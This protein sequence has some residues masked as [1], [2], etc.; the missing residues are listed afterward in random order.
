CFLWGRKRRE[1][2]RVCFL[3]HVLKPTQPLPKA[4]R[5]C[6]SVYGSGCRWWLGLW[7]SI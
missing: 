2:R 5:K 6:S 7:G 1:E 3:Y 4:S